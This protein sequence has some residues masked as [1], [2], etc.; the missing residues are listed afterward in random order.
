MADL[1]SYA[2]RRLV[3]A[4]RIYEAKRF[5][6]P[7]EFKPRPPQNWGRFLLRSNGGAE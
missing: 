6:A 1:E 7:V 3:T 5:D 2:G 4:L